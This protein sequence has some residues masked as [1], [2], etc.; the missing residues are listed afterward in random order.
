[1][2]K[3][4]VLIYLSVKQGVRLNMS[5]PNKG[6]SIL[7]G[8]SWVL[9]ALVAKPALSQEITTKVTSQ[10]R[11]VPVS[12]KAIDLLSSEIALQKYFI[13]I[14]T[15]TYKI[16]QLN[17]EQFCQDFPNNSKCQGTTTPGTPSTETDSE[18]NPIPVPVPPPAPPTAPSE[19]GEVESPSR[20][21]QKTGWAIVPEIS[22]LG[23]GGH[24]VKKIIP[25]VN[26][27]VGINAFGINVDVDGEEVEYDGDLDLFNVSTIL[28]LHPSKN[29]GFKLSAGAIFAN[30]NIE[31]TA[32]TE[33][34]I[35]IGNEEFENDVVEST[36]VEIEIT[37]DVAPYLGLGWGNAVAD[38]KGFGV[39]FN[40]GVM[41]G[42]SP[43]VEVTPNFN[44]NATQEQ[45][46]EAN[47]AAEDEEE[48]VEDNL[49]F[50][51][52]YPVAS[53]GISYQF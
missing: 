2:A 23:L 27:R 5:K 19:A 50:I 11:S 48:E 18:S 39:W 28:D 44:E 12:T 46:A 1:M 17:L 16:G 13:D 3:F 32:I 30:N 31:G 35:T 21:S 53:L 9:M 10:S 42:G 22:T 47:E 26:A 20:V 45:R 52:I 34:T 6:N 51:G 33:D 41:F 24:V 4:L 36:D 14:N 38:N 43:D 25:Q 8:L 15:K 7:W 29:S 40:L 49:A 37:R